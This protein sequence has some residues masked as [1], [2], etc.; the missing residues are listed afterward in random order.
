VRTANGGVAA[1][2]ERLTLIKSPDHAHLLINASQ[3]IAG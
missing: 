3:V 2:T 1:D